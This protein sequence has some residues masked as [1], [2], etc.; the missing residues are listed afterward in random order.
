MTTLPQTTPLRAPLPAAPIGV[1]HGPHI[2]AAPAAG[3]SGSDV[4]RVIRANLLLIII[5][6]ALSAVGGYFLNNFLLAHFPKYEAVG[7]VK[8]DPT[9]VLD[10]VQDRTNEL[11]ET[12]LSPRLVRSIRGVSAAQLFQLASACSR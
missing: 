6:L 12:R 10:L 2:V 9:I 3:M 5:F 4:W 1:P 8:I 11:G 7:L